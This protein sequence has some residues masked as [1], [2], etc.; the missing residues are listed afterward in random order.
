MRK[1][2]RFRMKIIKPYKKQEWFFEKEIHVN[3]LSDGRHRYRW[4][5]FSDDK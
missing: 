1:N 3:L 2:N 5:I 4:L